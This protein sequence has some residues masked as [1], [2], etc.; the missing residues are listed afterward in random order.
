M[1]PVG[2]NG[3]WHSHVSRNKLY[4][5]LGVLSNEASQVQISNWDHWIDENEL[6]V[7]LIQDCPYQ[8]QVKLTF[9]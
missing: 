2:L 6:I 8:L 4:V 7:H 5:G 1:T 9:L 3:H